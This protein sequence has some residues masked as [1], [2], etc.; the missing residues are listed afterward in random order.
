MP[1]LLDGEAPDE[2]LV[3]DWKKEHFGEEEAEEA[4]AEQKALRDALEAE[5]NEAEAQKR[6][7]D[8]ETYQSQKQAEERQ[9]SQE[10]RL[11]KDAE[12]R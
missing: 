5:A 9:A 2:D 3:L 7:V 10:A 12:A 4:H 1:L 8:V 11:Q 6:G